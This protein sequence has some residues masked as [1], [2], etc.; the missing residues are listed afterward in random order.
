MFWNIFGSTKESSSIITFLRHNQ[1]FC[2]FGA[3][4]HWIAQ[5]QELH[6]PSKQFSINT[7]AHKLTYLIFVLSSSVVASVLYWSS[8]FGASY[9]EWRSYLTTPSASCPEA[10]QSSSPPELLASGLVRQKLFSAFDL[11]FG[12]GLSEIELQKSCIKIFIV[13][14]S[15][16]FFI[17]VTFLSA[18]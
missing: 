16:R 3:T 7:I 10:N 6:I 1:I 4:L 5:N 11:I 18:I 2:G 15:Q 13:I 17:I 9:K 12:S 14:H 8:F